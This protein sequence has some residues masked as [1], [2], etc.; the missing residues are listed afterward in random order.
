MHVL[1]FFGI[2]AIV[3]ARI[4]HPPAEPVQPAV[5]S[6]AQLAPE[7]RALAVPGAT[8]AEVRA[9]PRHVERDP[10]PQSR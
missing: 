5:Q 7:Q 4:A 2:L 6:A 8:L 10:S 3:L 9:S 1:A